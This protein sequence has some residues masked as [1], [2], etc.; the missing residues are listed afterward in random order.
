MLYSSALAF[1]R[2]HKATTQEHHVNKSAVTRRH[3]TKQTNNSEVKAKV[4]AT[5]PHNQTFPY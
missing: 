3:Q 4:K 5:H 2:S 1:S